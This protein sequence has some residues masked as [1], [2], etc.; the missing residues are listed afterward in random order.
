MKPGALAAAALCAAA[1]IAGCHADEVEP[2]RT[3]ATSTVEDKKPGEEQTLSPES[4]FRDGAVEKIQEALRA[5]GSK[6]EAT[7]KLDEATE[8]ALREFQ[9]E[10]DLPK[11]GLP[12]HE[13]LRLLG[14]DP[15]DLY[16]PNRKRG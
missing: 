13:T 2:E 7:G 8:Q 3:D 11:T 5:Q 1:A 14:L 16:L 4:I 12:D 6:L 9:D 15:K 10:K